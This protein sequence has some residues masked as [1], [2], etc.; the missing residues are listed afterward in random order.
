MIAPIHYS[1]GRNLRDNH[2]HQHDAADFD[3][4][5]NRLDADRA[6]LK[7]GAGYVCGPLNGTGW[8][9][10]EGAL[11]RRWLAVD[12]DRIDADRLPDVRLWFAKFSGCARPTHSSKPEA[13][14][15]RVLIELS[16][17]ATRAEC[18]A[19]GEVL[20]RALADA[21]GDAAVIDPSTFRPE[22]P[23][24]LPSVGASLERFLGEPLDVDRHL[25]SPSA[26]AAAE[27]GVPPTEEDASPAPTEENRRVQKTSSEYLCPLLSSSVGGLAAAISRT[28]PT[29]EGQRG[30][31]L[32]DFAREVRTLLPNATPADLRAVA[33]EWHRQALPVIGTKALEV[34]ITDFL[35]AHDKVRIPH[36]AVMEQIATHAEQAPLPA[37]IEALGYG[38][39]GN[40]LVRLCVALQANN[41]AEPFFL[42]ARIAGDQVGLH[43]TDASKVLW[44]LVRDGVLDLVSKGVGRKASRYRYVWQAE[45]SA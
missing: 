16:R 26:G 24:F 4:M 44:L 14:R 27:P 33:A 1:R 8:R 23:V 43:F 3:E 40:N 15:E 38:D 39:A 12:L 21:F 5:V 2:P 37:G 9:C 34:T 30:R 13:P 19:I 6:P 20:V 32:F 28:L 11:P 10:A 18:F 7:D 31:R 41:G 29:A 42:S 36:G 45:V 25:A 35:N 22:Q 17:E